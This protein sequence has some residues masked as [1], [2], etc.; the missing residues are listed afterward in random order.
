[1]S[2]F[3]LHAIL[4][5]GRPETGDRTDSKNTLLDVDPRVARVENAIEGFSRPGTDTF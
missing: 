2:K 4:M 1:M 5:F 3:F